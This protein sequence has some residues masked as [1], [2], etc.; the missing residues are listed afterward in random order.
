VFESPV[1]HLFDA[2]RSKPIRVDLSDYSNQLVDVNAPY[3]SFVAHFL[4]VKKLFIIYIV[5]ADNHDVLKAPSCAEMILTVLWCPTLTVSDLRCSFAQVVRC[6]RYQCQV[7]VRGLGSTCN[8]VVHVAVQNMFVLLRPDGD[9]H[10]RETVLGAK[11]QSPQ[12]SARIVLT[13]LHRYR[14][15][16]VMYSLFF[17]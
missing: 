14:F 5:P 16:K 9:R 3:F 10:P 1:H 12:M 17:T 4:K 7:L 8:F 2:L 13:W 6:Q 11:E 15:C